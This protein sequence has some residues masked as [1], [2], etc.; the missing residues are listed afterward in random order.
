MS[1]SDLTDLSFRYRIKSSSKDSY[2]FR[3]LK[4][5]RPSERQRMV[6]RA[7]RFCYLAD[8]LEEYSQIESMDQSKLFDHLEEEFLNNRL[9]ISGVEQSATLLWRQSSKK[10]S[11]NQQERVAL[12]LRLDAKS[13]SLVGKL[14]NFLRQSEDQERVWREFLDHA[15]IAAVQLG[16]FQKNG[17][18]SGLSDPRIY[19]ETLR[20]TCSLEAHL[21][22]LQTLLYSSYSRFKQGKAQH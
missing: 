3:Y 2:L 11:S 17:D 19:E 9:D 6:L 12:T 15:L 8:A 14:L 16:Y 20:A 4:K 1:A 22:V 13:N 5:F 7:L 10:E 18:Y 21:K